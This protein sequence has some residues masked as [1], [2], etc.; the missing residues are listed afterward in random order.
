MKRYALM[1]WTPEG[2]VNSDRN[3]TPIVDG[4]YAE[5]K[6]FCNL[7]QVMKGVA[8]CGRR[9]KIPPEQLES[10]KET[11]RK[12]YLEILKRN[13]QGMLNPVLNI[14]GDDISAGYFRL[15]CQGIRVLIPVSPG[16]AWKFAKKAT[17]F[18]YTVTV[19]EGYGINKQAGN[20]EALLYLA[21]WGDPRNVV[22][23]KNIIVILNNPQI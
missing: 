17:C 7:T 6:E 5:R 8:N 4:R 14:F 12:N 11:S 15:A 18:S 20:A 22:V 2:W 1:H 13:E 16:L 3:Q 9:N 19:L 21:T 23:N 10:L